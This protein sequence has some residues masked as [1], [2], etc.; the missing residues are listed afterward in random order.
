MGGSFCFCFAPYPIL[1]RINSSL[2]IITNIREGGKIPAFAGMS[3][4][5]IAAM[6]NGPPEGDPSHIDSGGC[7]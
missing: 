3:E 6:E 7:D 4:Q 2:A 1:V 5:I